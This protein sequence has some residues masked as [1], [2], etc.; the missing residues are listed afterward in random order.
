MRILR[1]TI[2]LSVFAVAVS[3]GDETN[4]PPTKITIDSVAYSNVTW[5]T[6]TP[7]TVTIFYKTGIASIPLEKLPPDLQK[8]FGY[9]PQKAAAY[10][11]EE[12][13]QLELARRQQELARQEAEKRKE[14]VA[15]AIQQRFEE[16]QK[17]QEEQRQEE[18]RQRRER[19]KAILFSVIVQQA[20][21]EG[22]LVNC[23]RAAPALFYVEGL[24]GVYDDTAHAIVVE[25]TGDFEYTTTM[26][27]YKKVPKYKYLGR[28]DDV[29]PQPDGRRYW[30][31]G[32]PIEIH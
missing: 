10:R 22:A 31:K 28:P 9:D 8:R 30:W 5:G 27:A 19:E 6:V 17:R 26:G 11:Q 3:F 16:E 13:K 7:A 14:R 20:L 24:T 25:R 29:G 32:G 15:T 18:E 21:P 23:S 12:A 1:V 4:A 2:L